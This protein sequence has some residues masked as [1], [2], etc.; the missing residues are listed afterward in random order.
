MLHDMSRRRFVATA[1]GSV[2]AL[3]LPNIAFGCKPKTLTLK[4]RYT[5]ERVFGDARMVTLA[6]KWRS[7]DS[8][9]GLL[10]LDP[11]ITDGFFSTCIAIQEV[12]VEVAHLLDTEPVHNAKRY[13]ELRERDTLRK[14]KSGKKCWHLEQLLTTTPKYTLKAIDEE[15]KEFAMIE[16]FP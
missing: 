3:A 10:T 4:S 16:L 6:I 13:Y 14:K 9:D 12:P 8:G 5:G 2:A 11:N 1:I 15:G 7:D